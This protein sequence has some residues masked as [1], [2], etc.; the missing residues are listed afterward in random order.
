CNRG[1]CTETPRRRGAH[2]GS[3]GVAYY[4]V[5]RI[6][7]P[8]V[9]GDADGDSSVVATAARPREP[10]GRAKARLRN[11]RRHRTDDR[12]HARRGNAL[13]SHLASRR[14]GTHPTTPPT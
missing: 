3:L 6:I 1:L 13:R 4:Y 12:R 7:T 8:H 11:D 14:V 5:R 10:G 2:R 9:T